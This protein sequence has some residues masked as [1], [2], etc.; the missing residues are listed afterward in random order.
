MA[1]S[2][3]AIGFSMVFIWYGDGNTCNFISILQSS[4]LN[5]MVLAAD[6]GRCQGEVRVS[7]VTAVTKTIG[8]RKLKLRVGAESP[9]CVLSRNSTLRH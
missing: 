8:T 5:E 4:A 2:H 3:C 6:G 9:S 7:A 1:K